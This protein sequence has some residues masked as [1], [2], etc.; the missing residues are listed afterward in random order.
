MESLNISHSNSI[1]FITA[2]WKNEQHGIYV[3]QPDLYNFSVGKDTIYTVQ[4]DSAFGLIK[5]AYLKTEVYPYRNTY[6]LFIAAD[7]GAEHY[8]YVFSS[9]SSSGDYYPVISGQNTTSRSFYEGR[10]TSVPV[11][12]SAT[13]NGVTSS[14]YTN[15]NVKDDLG[16]I[17]WEKQPQY[18]N[19]YSSANYSPSDV[20]VAYKQVL[21]YNI[22]ENYNLRWHSYLNDTTENEFVSFINPSHNIHTNQLYLFSGRAEDHNKEVLELIMVD[23]KGEL[24]IKP[25][26]L[27][28]VSYQFAF[29]SGKKINDNAILYPAKVKNKLAFIKI[30]LE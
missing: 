11:H 9:E 8:P 6:N 29:A 7:Q 10:P 18:Q 4:T 5:N 26:I 24:S 23:N 15:P 27:M 21:L 16:K 25:V 12:S 20:D 3:W 28:R 17:S 13:V 30:S 22:D 19:Q 2:Y 14:A 1:V